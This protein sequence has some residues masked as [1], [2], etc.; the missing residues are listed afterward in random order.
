MSI[1]EAAPA[2]VRS[3]TSNLRGGSSW[4]CCPPCFGSGYTD[5]NKNVKGKSLLT[6]LG[7]YNSSGR[8]AGSAKDQASPG[9]PDYIHTENQMKG[10]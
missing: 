3:G 10:W 7:E 2:G 5:F 4:L 8:E 1:M 6:V 9:G